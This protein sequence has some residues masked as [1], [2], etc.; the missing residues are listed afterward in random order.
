MQKHDYKADSSVTITIG[1]DYGAFHLINVPIQISFADS[2]FF[3]VTRD[4]QTCG[5]LS[6][7]C[8][9]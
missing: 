1:L 9:K 8:Q 2:A 7:L 6:V 4:I 3:T 5:N